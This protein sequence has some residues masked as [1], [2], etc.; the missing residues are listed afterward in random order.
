[1]RSDDR[2]AIKKELFPE[3]GNDGLIG[4]GVYR[5]QKTKGIG[6]LDQASREEVKIVTWWEKLQKKRNIP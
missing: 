3:G 2:F 1:M 4:G 5:E 6:V